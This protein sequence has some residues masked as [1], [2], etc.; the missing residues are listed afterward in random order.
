MIE[1]HTINKDNPAN[2]QIH[3][4][5]GTNKKAGSYIDAALGCLENKAGN[6]LLNLVIW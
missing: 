5:S 4:I 6:M 3:G 2:N 1:C